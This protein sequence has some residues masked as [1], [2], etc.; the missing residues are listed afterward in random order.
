M[1]RIIRYGPS[2]GASFALFGVKSVKIKKVE[3]HLNYSG[4]FASLPD[5][6]GKISTDIYGI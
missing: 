2:L 3:I 1:N 6:T 5:D 4:R